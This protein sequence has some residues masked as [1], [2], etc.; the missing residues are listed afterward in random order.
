MDYQYIELEEH[1][2]RRESELKYLGS[3]ITQENDVKT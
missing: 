3:I 1:T 2:L